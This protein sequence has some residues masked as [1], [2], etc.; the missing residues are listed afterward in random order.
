[1]VYSVSVSMQS[2]QHLKVS[3]FGLPLFIP[4]NSLKKLFLFNLYN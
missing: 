1:M 3:A 4:P 2:L